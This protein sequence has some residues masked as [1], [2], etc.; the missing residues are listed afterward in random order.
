MHAVLVDGEAHLDVREHGEGVERQMP[1]GS[2]IFFGVDTASDA[3]AR[4]W[5]MR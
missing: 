5:I 3:L 4:C 2:N 1:P